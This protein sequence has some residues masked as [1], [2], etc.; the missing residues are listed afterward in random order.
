MNIKTAWGLLF[1]PPLHLSFPLARVSCCCRLQVSAG[2][3]RVVAAGQCWQHGEGPEVGWEEELP[4]SPQT[5]TG[6]RTNRHKYVQMLSSSLTPG[7]RTNTLQTQIH[8]QD[9]TQHSCACSVTWLCFS[10]EEKAPSQCLYSS[11]TESD[12]S[13]HFKQIK[14]HSSYTWVTVIA[15][16]SFA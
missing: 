4:L 5:G 12:L 13:K 10:E 14:L 7:H 8:F 1:S 15:Q 6:K 2:S 11:L 3:E 16:H 9:T